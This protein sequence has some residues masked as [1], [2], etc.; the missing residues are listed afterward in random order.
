MWVSFW[1]LQ[2]TG[3]KTSYGQEAHDTEYAPGY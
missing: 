3:Y 2:D 1:D